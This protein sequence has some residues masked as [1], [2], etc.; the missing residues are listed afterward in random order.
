MQGKLP[1]DIGRLCSQYLLEEIAAG[2]CIDSTH[3]PLFFTLMALTTEDVSKVRVGKLTSQS[4]LTLR[5]LKKFLNV[6]CVHLWLSE[7]MLNVRQYLTVAVTL[8]TGS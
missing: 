6:K 4:I 1:E 5:A 8:H 2:G 3:Q 7:V